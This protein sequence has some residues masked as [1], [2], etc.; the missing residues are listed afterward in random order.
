M[1]FLVFKCYEL[2]LD[3]VVVYDFFWIYVVDIDIMNGVLWDF[4]VLI[5][6]EDVVGCFVVEFIICYYGLMYMVQLDFKSFVVEKIK[7]F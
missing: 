3:F 2:G 7:E 4:F 5:Y 1:F 6:Q